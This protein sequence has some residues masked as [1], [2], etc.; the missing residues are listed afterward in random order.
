VNEADGEHMAPAIAAALRSQLAI[1][2]GLW[3]RY[4]A[5]AHRA[6]A[7]GSMVEADEALPHARFVRIHAAQS[8]ASAIDHLTAWRLLVEGRL[9]PIQAQTTL[10]RAAIE[11]SVR[12]RWLVDATIDSKT[13]VARGYATRRDDQ[14]QRRRFEESR[15]GLA[16][17]EERVR[18]VE[19]TARTA[20]ERLAE[21]E[22]WRSAANIPMVGFTDT[23]A[24]VR[25][26]G[27]ERWFRLASGAAHG[28]EWALNASTIQPS[29]DAADRPGVGHGRVSLND[30]VTLALTT[31]S[32][33]AVAAAVATFEAYT[34]A[35]ATGS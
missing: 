6:A 16:D 26:Y 3:A 18:P 35:T 13:R 17:D 9:V 12:C 27:L 20:A 31:T 11:G 25:A 28:K 10:M 14:I 7:P 22:A 8:L 2:D 21:L 1:L 29:P 32:L 24:L 5:A 23:T 33:R 4:E 30:D 19:A 34:A 15:E